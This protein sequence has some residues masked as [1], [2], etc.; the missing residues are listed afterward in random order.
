[1]VTPKRERATR[2]RCSPRGS[3]P[4]PGVICQTRTLAAPG[5]R[6]PQQLMPARR[7]RGQ[8]LHHIYA[9]T[10]TAALPRARQHRDLRVRLPLLGLEIA[11]HDRTRLVQHVLEPPRMPFDDDPFSRRR[12]AQHVLVAVDEFEWK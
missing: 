6:M 2:R 5:G 12:R 11:R 10:G 8:P 4:P 3:R 9:L 7:A 1:M